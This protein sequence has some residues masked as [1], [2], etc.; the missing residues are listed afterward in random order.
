MNEITAIPDPFING[1]K[2]W[3]EGHS[4]YDYYLYDYYGVNSETGAAQ[5]HIWKSDENGVT[6]RQYDADGKPLLTEKYTDS[7]KG[8]TGDS[9]I[10][11][12]FG[13]VSNNLKYKSFELDFLVTYAVGGKI[14]DY[15]YAGLMNEGNYGRSVHA[16]QLKGWRN[17]GDITDIPRMEYGNTNI[18]PTSDRWLTDASYVTLKNV[19]FGYT[20]S[21]KAVRDLGIKT[22]KV[23]VA[24]EN[25]YMLN[26][27]KGMDP[28]EAFS[29]TNSNVYLPSRVFSFGVNVA[30]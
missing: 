15:N 6:T 22:L 23:Y 3:A 12:F 10:P 27:R 16:D 7:E 25:L 11:D 26:A 28:Q 20:F 4:I 8:Y 30:F 1:S 29:G 19:N 18:N 9:A 2:R 5:Y 17:P 13:S 14:L 24:G 21:Q